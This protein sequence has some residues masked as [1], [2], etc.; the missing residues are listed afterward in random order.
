ML[1]LVTETNPG[2]AQW[3]PL[4]P[5]GTVLMWAGSSA[6]SGYLLCDG[7]TLLRASYPDLFAA[8]GTAFGSDDEDSFSL[9]D[10]R[11]RAPLGAGQGAGL[12]NRTLA[13]QGGTETVTLSSAE[14]PSHTHT[15][16]APGGQGNLGLVIADGTN[17][18]TS[19]DGSI[20]E[21]NVWTTPR[22]LTINDTGGGGAHANMQP[23]LTLN[24]IIK[25]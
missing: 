14:M 7:S 20:G 10:L 18:A 24:F 25:S 13:Q 9:P 8:I 6:P 15:S 17:T 5:T 12:S 11:G 22:T 2:S 4:V 1:S 23:F 21:I 16:N 19:T 3:F